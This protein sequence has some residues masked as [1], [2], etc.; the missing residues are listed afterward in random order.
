[1]IGGIYMWVTH[2][3]LDELYQDTVKSDRKTYDEKWQTVLK[4]KFHERIGTFKN[5]E[6]LQPTL[7][8]QKQYEHYTRYSAEITT[9][10]N[11][12]MQMYVLVP[13]NIHGKK[14]QQYL[15]YMV[16][17]METKILWG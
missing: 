7:V 10:P 9:L 1:M 4:E 6:P 11:V 3:F 2:P 8:E 15:P 5:D 16:T 17:D 12:R 14:L 13:N